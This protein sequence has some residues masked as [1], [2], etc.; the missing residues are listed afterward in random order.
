M[1]KK[2][3]TFI[4]AVF[5]IFALCSCNNASSPPRV[6]PEN[7]YDEI[8]EEAVEELMANMTRE[9]KIA[10]MLIIEPSK[11]GSIP[12]PAPG[13]V[14][15]FASDFTTPYK[16]KEFIDSLKSQSELPLIVSVDQEGGRVQ[17]LSSLTAPKATFIP[18]MYNLGKTGDTALARKTGNVMATEMCALGINLTFAPVLDVYSNPDNTVIGNRSFSE[19]P[20][21]VSAM[22]LSLADGLTEKGVMPCYKHFP[23]HG[24]TA[25]DSHL[26]LPIINKTKAQLYNT[27]LIPFKAAIESGAEMIMIGH[28]ALPQITGNNTPSSLSKAIITDLLKNEMG[29]NGLIITDSLKMKAVTNNYSEEDIYRMAVEAGADILLMPKDPQ[30]A[31]RVIDEGFTEERINESVEKILF[32]KI[33][34]L[35]QTPEYSLSVIGST[36]HKNII[37]QIPH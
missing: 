33:K 28:I 35:S 14:I 3:I 15:L 30:L 18:P 11:S 29:Y 6:S 34:N 36:E 19:S 10:Q 24:D 37:N 32:Y 23:G 4:L 21:T 31:V 5:V 22:A 20:S 26:A 25:T 17:R 27:E 7:D 8:T 2:L 16:T 13:G 1:T 9:E 12:S